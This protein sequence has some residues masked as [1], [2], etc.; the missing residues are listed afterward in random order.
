VLALDVDGVIAVDE[1]AATPTVE[2]S[3][4][5]WG[6]WR[7]QI[8]VPI[9]APQILA[10]LAPHFEI[11]WASAWGH[12]AHTAL[13]PVLDLPQE[14][15]MF[16]PVQFGKPTAVAS[17]AATRPWVLIEDDT[18]GGTEAV[19]SDHVVLVDPRR[20]IADIDTEKLIALVG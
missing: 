6:R 7:R 20:G 18:G 13:A 19:S 16:L 2:C 11:V 9:N 15:W 17:Y 14:P 1:P 4:S 3:V 5:A 8:K 12:N 10:Q